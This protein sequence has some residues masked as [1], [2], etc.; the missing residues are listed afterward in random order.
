MA[1][2]TPLMGEFS[3]C[4]IEILFAEARMALLPMTRG[5]TLPKKIDG[6]L[7]LCV[8]G[9]V[10]VETDDGHGHSDE[11][12]VFGSYG[13]KYMTVGVSEIDTPL[14]LRVIACFFFVFFLSPFWCK[15]L[16]S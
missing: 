8:R 4:T 5:R 3:D 14:F 1:A 10:L 7:G 12:M 11:D 6:A 16:R 2:A 15:V 9:V 13:R